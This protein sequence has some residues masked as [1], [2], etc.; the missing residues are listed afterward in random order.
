MVVECLEKP[1]AE[2]FFVLVYCWHYRRDC[3]LG[4]DFYSCYHRFH[5]EHDWSRLFLFHLGGKIYSHS[6]YRSLISLIHSRPLDESIQS[7][8]CNRLCW[9]SRDHFFEFIANLW[10][11]FSAIFTKPTFVVC[12]ELAHVGGVKLRDFHF[13]FIPLWLNIGRG[14]ID[15]SSTWS[16]CRDGFTFFLFFPLFNYWILGV[17]ISNSNIIDV[18]FFFIIGFAKGGVKSSQNVFKNLIG[19]F[20]LQF[21][22]FC[23]FSFFPFFLMLVLLRRTSFSG[24]LLSP[25]F[26]SSDTVT[27]YKFPIWPI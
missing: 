17:T 2:N 5:F 13:I 7:H 1:D 6:F 18:N 9:I 20:I 10:M 12:K 24:H 22:F 21:S 8:C 16:R 23:F 3:L 19:I 14:T 27:I 15:L 4:L 11:I 26:Q 25:I